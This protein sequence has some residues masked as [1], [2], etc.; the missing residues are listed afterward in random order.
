MYL[1]IPISSYKRNSHLNFQIKNDLND[2]F[3]QKIKTHFS[4]SLKAPNTQE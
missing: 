4:I 3:E 1:K 2:S